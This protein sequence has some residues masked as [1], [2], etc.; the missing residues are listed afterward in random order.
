[1][2]NIILVFTCIIFAVIGC[3]SSRKSSPASLDTL[4][5]D[6]GMT[7]VET[8]DS[9]ALFEEMESYRV[10]SGTEVTRTPEVQKSF[11]NESGNRYFMIVGCFSIPK[12]ADAFASRMREMGYNAAILESSGNL[13][14]VSAKSY[15]SYQ[16][17]I[18]DIAKFRNEVTPDAWV[19][20][21]R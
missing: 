1:M 6:T 2:K 20:V 7:A 8:V 4:F 19:Y 21:K 9:A 12:N 15:A 10:G 18:A 14:M 16:E 13:Q 3:K 5:A 11:T 17:S